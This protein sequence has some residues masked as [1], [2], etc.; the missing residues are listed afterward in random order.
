MSAKISTAIRQRVVRVEL[1]LFCI[2][3]FPAGY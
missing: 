2:E 1:F 3:V